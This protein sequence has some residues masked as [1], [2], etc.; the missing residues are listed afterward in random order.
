MSN[1][2]VCAFEDIN[3]WG[4]DEEGAGSTPELVGGPIDTPMNDEWRQGSSY[5]AK[6]KKRTKTS[7]YSSQS[8]I[9]EEVDTVTEYG[10]NRSSLYTAKKEE[11]TIV[12]GQT[13]DVKSV[14]TTNDQ[15]NDRRLRGGHKKRRKQSSSSS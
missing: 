10:N 4:Q 15:G 3:L 14:V 5:F 1:S 11:V 2:V 8:G 7:S 12:N 6:K 9:N 13:V